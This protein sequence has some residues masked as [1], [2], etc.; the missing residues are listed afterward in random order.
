M[1]VFANRTFLHVAEEDDDDLDCAEVLPSMQHAKSLPWGPRRASKDQQHEQHDAYIARLR[2]QAEQLRRPASPVANSASAGSAGTEA[3]SNRLEQRRMASPTVS[4]WSPCTTPSDREVA[5]SCHRTPPGDGDLGSGQVPQISLT[6]MPAYVYPSTGFYTAQVFQH[7]SLTAAPP[8]RPP[9]YTPPPAVA[10]DSVEDKESMAA[11]YEGETFVIHDMPR[12]MSLEEMI[13]LFRSWGVLHECD[14]C[15]IPSHH[16][17]K[18][19]KSIAVGYGHVHFKCKRAGDVFY[20]ALHGKRLPGSQTKHS[21]S[22]RRR[23]FASISE[24]IAKRRVAPQDFW[25]SEEM[26]SLLML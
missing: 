14:F 25:A 1:K 19:N 26:R 9:T 11:D 18:G 21:I 23:P 24:A 8:P 22:V 5:Y 13:K 6:G 16:L 12:S 15:S 4:T 3:T 2:E 17:Q 7:S 20:E 10:Q